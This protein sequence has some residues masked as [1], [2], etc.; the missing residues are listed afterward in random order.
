MRTKAIYK[1]RI[2]DEIY[3]IYRISGNVSPTVKPVSAGLA[4]DDAGEYSTKFKKDCQRYFINSSEL[5]MESTAKDKV[6]FMCRLYL[7]NAFTDKPKIPKKALEACKHAH[8]YEK[9]RHEKLVR[10]S[11]EDAFDFVADKPNINTI[12]DFKTEIL[13]TARFCFKF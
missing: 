10:S 5:S 3:V 7:D 2:S 13:K 9:N 8:E 12:E 4:Y 1:Y 6:E 11:L